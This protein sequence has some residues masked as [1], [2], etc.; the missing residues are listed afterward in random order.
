MI[1]YQSSSGWGIETGDLVAS[2]TISSPAPAVK[3]GLGTYGCLLEVLAQKH[4][5]PAVGGTP[6]SWLEDGDRLSIEGRFKTADGS[7]G[8][9][10]SVWGVVV[11][12]PTWPS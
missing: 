1:A 6:M 12:G 5:L 9:F 11:P 10:G 3:K 2:G 7:M 4:E 8:G